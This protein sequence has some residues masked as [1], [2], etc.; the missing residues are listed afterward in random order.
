MKVSVKNTADV[1]TK[2]GFVGAGLKPASTKTCGF[3]IVRGVQLGV[4]VAPAKL[5]DNTRLV[6]HGKEKQWLEAA[7]V[8]RTN[9]TVC[10][11]KSGIYPAPRD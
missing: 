9:W 4:L 5:T 10:A 11:A 7:G 8:A 2:Y 6:R 1:T 3:F